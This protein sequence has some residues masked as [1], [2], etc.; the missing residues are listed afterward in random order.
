MTLSRLFLPALLS[1]AR[2]VRAPY[3]VKCMAREL[4]DNAPADLIA[5]D[6]SFKAGE[7]FLL[8][9]E[10]GC[11]ETCIIAK[12]EYLPTSALLSKAMTPDFLSKTRRQLGAS[13][14]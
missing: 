1:G 9:Y 7:R 12:L 4:S 11:G 14:N 13:L 10:M 3:L 8:S 6:E 5:I 2:N